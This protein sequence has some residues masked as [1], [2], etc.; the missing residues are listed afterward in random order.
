MLCLSDFTFVCPTEIVAFN[1]RYFEFEYGSGNLSTM[2][3]MH[4][5]ELLK[6]R[7]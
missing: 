2:S 7:C 1:D 3:D 6:L 5:L 4:A